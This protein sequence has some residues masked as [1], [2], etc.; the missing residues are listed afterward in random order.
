MSKSAVNVKA[1]IPFRPI[2]DRLL[3]RQDK[4]DEKF[5]KKSLLIKP[6][7]SQ[8]RPPTG[9]VLAA[10]DGRPQPDGSLVPLV[11]KPGDRIHFRRHGGIP[12][13]VEVSDGVF[14]EFVLVREDDVL[15]VVE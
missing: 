10:G 2:R 3:I 9:V 5:G 1:A 14:E 15:G 12:V 6:E 11:V 13:D 7:T 4:P 8:E